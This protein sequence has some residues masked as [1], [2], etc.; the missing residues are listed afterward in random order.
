MDMDLKR[1]LDGIIA[2]SADPDRLEKMG[3]EGLNAELSFL[4]AYDKSTALEAVG[5]LNGR[6]PYP[7][8]G[9][10]IA[11]FFA[12][13]VFG[14]IDFIRTMKESGSDLSN[15]VYALD[16]ITIE[17]E[18]GKA[19]LDL[20][21][22]EGRDSLMRNLPSSLKSNVEFWEY[23]RSKG[24]DTYIIKND[25]AI[26]E[27]NIPD[28]I[29]ALDM[30]G[31][32]YEYSQK[33]VPKTEEITG[34]VKG[35]SQK[36]S[37]GN[38]AIGYMN[39]QNADKA[40]VVA[41]VDILG[42]EKSDGFLSNVS[43][44]LLSD[45]ELIKIL[46]GKG[47][48]LSQLSQRA[49]FDDK[50]IQE[51]IDAVDY[52]QPR[53]YG[54]LFVPKSEEVLPLING[55]LAKGA[56][57]VA[58]IGNL[59]WKN[60]DRETALEV[61]GLLGLGEAEPTKAFLKKVSPELLGSASFLC[62][63]RKKN[64]ADRWIIENYRKDTNYQ[65]VNELIAM[66]PESRK[67]IA[68]SANLSSEQLLV[69]AKGDPDFMQNSANFSFINLR[70]A[71]GIEM[72]SA[73]GFENTHALIKG[74]GKFGAIGD[75][76]F[77]EAALARSEGKGG[78]IQGVV[79]K[80]TLILDFAKKADEENFLIFAEK[81][82]EK[83]LELYNSRMLEL[84]KVSSSQAVFE[85]IY[86]L[87]KTPQQQL[88]TLEKFRPHNIIGED[89]AIKF[90]EI[91]GSN[92]ATAYRKLGQDVAVKPAVVQKSLELIPPE[93]RGEILFVLRDNVQKANIDT[94]EQARELRK[95]DPDIFA[96]EPK[97][98]VTRDY[99]A[100]TN[101]Y[102]LFE[103][104]GEKALTTANY[105][106]NV[107]QLF[108]WSE[109]RQSLSKGRANS[110][111]PP[112]YI[113]NAVGTNP[114][115][116]SAFYNAQGRIK[117]QK[118]V[119]IPG[120]FAAM[121]QMP[122]YQNAQE[123]SRTDIIKLFAHLGCFEHGVPKQV[124]ERTAL[125]QKVSEKFDA[126]KIHSKFGSLPSGFGLSRLL[127][128][129]DKSQQLSSEHRGKFDSK[130]QNAIAFFVK[131]L[132]ESSASTQYLKSIEGIV[133]LNEEQLKMK[134]L[135]GKRILDFETVASYVLTHFVKEKVTYNER[136]KD[137]RSELESAAFGD[138]N[139]KIRQAME[140]IHNLHGHLAVLVAK[141]ENGTITP[142]EAKQRSQMQEQMEEVRGQLDKLIKEEGSPHLQKLLEKSELSKRPFGVEHVL[143]SFMEISFPN[144]KYQNVAVA[145]VRA[146]YG[147]GEES[148]VD[149]LCEIF[150]A[151]QS[152]P[153]KYFASKVFDEQREGVTYLWAEVDN[154]QLYSIA[155]AVDGTCMRPQHA[156]EAA[157]WEVATSPDVKLA[158]ILDEH[159]QP[160]AYVRANYDISGEGIYIDI[161]DSKKSIAL[162]NEDVWKATDRALTDMAKKMDAEGK[163]VRVVNYR[164][165]GYNKL[166]VQFERLD[167]AR[168][169]LRGRP[170]KHPRA[171]TS[172]GDSEPR[173]Q[174]EVW[175]NPKFLG[176]R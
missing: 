97:A 143:Q 146:G 16:I 12:P 96:K 68:E 43:D 62:E 67:L 34:L 93:R 8:L 155:K 145:A 5:Y 174:K 172:Y 128:G 144:A 175:A 92:V 6:E 141:N 113:V 147:R 55:Y 121:E 27:M 61:V 29:A 40:S 83:A 118:D 22:I 81:Y 171:S 53:D 115:D 70:G 89:A 72:M 1:K 151:A 111:I 126:E 117:I 154:P 56:A 88:E 149:R 50:T 79:T 150:E 152:A 156:N 77:L 169:I 164:N 158:F 32:V 148:A 58:V 159:R 26:A 76:G 30:M 21:G 112:E 78:K 135:H 42:A 167:P 160:I 13:E 15:L 99:G 104:M 3:E 86:A 59:N 33:F 60:A 49:T 37:A 137:S 107:P 114:Q 57:G 162:N 130:G 87:A 132:D 153:Q 48:S 161:V 63:L 170:Y 38:E 64:V 120:A 14:D 36:G 168:I 45:F 23:A 9:D 127:E 7:D 106:S 25:I 123:P 85:K 157:L 133:P 173:V 66:M 41:V 74:A 52:F 19:L 122:F 94:V 11:G 131:S 4:R 95:L 47:V 44:E 125:I 124:Q 51:K 119:F 140:S 103:G 2:L 84:V 142:E 69:W 75:F 136:K 163:T 71:D 73:I 138:S 18:K 39:W 116:I 65:E 176:G 80:D 129:Q 139:T 20:L 31:D 105:Y 24:V 102:T 166:Q 165:D 109:A 35:L 17:T 110:P 101:E 134:E 90:L 10:Q 91:S 108:A 100:K 28:K 82:P 98:V 54:N 46:Q